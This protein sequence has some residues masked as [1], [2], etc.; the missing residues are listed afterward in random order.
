MKLDPKM[1]KEINKAVD[2]FVQKNRSAIENA[3]AIAQ[4]EKTVQELEKRV[5][6]LEAESGKGSKDKSSFIGKHDIR[7]TKLEQWRPLV[8]AELKK[9]QEAHKKTSDFV[10]KH[11]ARLTRLESWR[12]LIVK[13]VQRIGKTK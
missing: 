3:K 4:L 6:K 2:G 11:D 1:M 13:E 10:G 7:L 5:Q 9:Q 12:P 8:V